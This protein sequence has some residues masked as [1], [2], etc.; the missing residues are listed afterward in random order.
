VDDAVQLALDN[1]AGLRQSEIAVRAAQRAMD[2]SWGGLIPGLSLGAGASRP[3]VPS[4]GGT[5]STV[6]INGSVS[7]ALTLTT[8]V[9]GT[10]Q[11]DKVLYDQAQLSYQTSRRTVELSVRKAYY[12]LLIARENIGV[13]QKS[14]DTAQ[15]NYDQ[16][17]A[18]RKAGLAPE[19]DSL[20]ALVALE[21]LKPTMD[22][23]QVSY[24]NQLADFRQLLGMDQARVPA[25]TGTLDSATPLAAENTSTPA[26]AN[27]T[28]LL[29]ASPTITALQMSLNLAR[30]REAAAQRSM[31]SPA[32]SLALSYR[33]TS[34]DNAATWKDAGSLSATATFPLDKMLPW[35]QEHQSA[36]AMADSVATLEI[37]LAEARTSA[38]LQVRSLVRRID[39]ARSSLKALRLNATLA[40][41]TYTLTEEAYRFGTRDVLGLQ[42]AQDNLQAARMQ[43]LSQLYTLISAALDLEY[44]LE[45]PFGTL[46]S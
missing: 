20:T 4:T 41:R 36:A 45:V 5:T 16:T 28:A 30:A 44:A 21:K 11:I 40:E 25:L 1:N 34:S 33:P 6:T 46:G 24:E 32:L 39:Q 13:L 42:N 37:S 12:S 15:K 14:V 43:V 8:A 17:E 26:L 31:Y 3:N 2:L 22:S 19:L 35:S 18:R 27:L 7:T 9:I 38:D 10:M 29:G 23:A